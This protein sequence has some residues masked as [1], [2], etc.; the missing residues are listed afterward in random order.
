VH[1]I[2]HIHPDDSC[3][4]RVGAVIPFAGFANGPDAIK[5]SI[6][7]GGVDGATSLLGG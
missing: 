1:H 3:P 7:A 6:Q 2:G 5:F 4:N